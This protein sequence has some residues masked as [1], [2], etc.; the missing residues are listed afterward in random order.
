VLLWKPPQTD[1]RNLALGM[2][3]EAVRT[4][5]TRLNA[6]AGITAD[7]SPSDYFDEALQQL[8]MRFQEAHGLAVDGIAGLRTQALLD[9]TLAGAD[10]PRLSATAR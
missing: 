10:T 7:G 6:W 4:L 8:V 2:W 9:S 5:R 1:T 3:A